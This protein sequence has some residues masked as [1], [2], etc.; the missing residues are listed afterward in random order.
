[1][2]V[3]LGPKMD[4]LL[5]KIGQDAMNDVV[6][7]AAGILPALIE[8]IELMSPAGA[9]AAE[10]LVLGALQIPAQSALSAAEAKVVL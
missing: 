4:A 2:A 3:V 6:D 5:K 7:P 9:Q 10:A 8:Q 1:M